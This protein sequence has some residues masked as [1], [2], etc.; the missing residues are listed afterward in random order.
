M[1]FKHLSPPLKI[2]KSPL[3]GQKSK[4]SKVYGVTYQN[5]CEKGRKPMKK[6]SAQSGLPVLRKRPKTS[7][8]YH[9][10]GKL[11]FREVF[12]LFLQSG[13]PDWAGSFFIDF[14]PFS[15]KFWCMLSDSSGWIPNTSHLNFPSIPFL[16]VFKAFLKGKFLEFREIPKTNSYS[17]IWM[18]PGILDMLINS[19]Y[20]YKITWKLLS[21]YFRCPEASFFVGSTIH[22]KMQELQMYRSQKHFLQYHDFCVEKW[23]SQ[24]VI[25]ISLLV[26]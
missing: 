20:C 4:L 3:W 1:N 22:R 10:L 24:K 12:R 19:N 14:L 13:N 11:R 6:D 5:L 18:L 7:R 16:S 25:I 26:Q 17:A 15:H 2:W 9:I 23:L 21:H 8:K